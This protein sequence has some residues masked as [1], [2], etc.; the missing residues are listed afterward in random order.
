MTRW[1]ISLKTGLVILAAFSCLAAG[2]DWLYPNDPLD[3]ASA[4]FI[5]PGQDPEFPL[6][7]DIMGRDIAAGIAHG[8]RITLA[9]GLIASLLATLAGTT[10]GVI[11]GYFGGWVDHTLMRFTELFQAIPHFL[12]AIMLVSIL[13]PSIP[14][15]ILSI[16]LTGWPGIARIVRAETLSLRER[17]F[18]KISEVMG[19]G[20]SRIVL[21][22]ILPNVAAPIF[23]ASSLLTSMA[24][25]TE[26]GLSFL[27]LGDSSHV[28]W[29]GMIG[30]SRD[31]LLDAP[32]MTLIPGAATI[33]MVF[34]LSLI[35]DGLSRH[36]R[37]R[38]TP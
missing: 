26:S 14:H 36:L 30:S 25:L 15:I 28:S 4:P 24:V 1:P 13:G 11:A 2:A 16:G 33:L 32:Y 23:V 22:H 12:F 18:V 21:T 31:A 8:A 10:L 19:A 20:H 9:T 6:G 37:P 27:G 29:G 34:S 7:T 38:N 5:E 17:D 35:G 3:L